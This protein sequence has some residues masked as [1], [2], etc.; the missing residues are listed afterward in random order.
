MMGR[1]NR[2][3]IPSVGAARDAAGTPVPRPQLNPWYPYCISFVAAVG[4]FLFGYDLLIM[5][6]AQLFLKDY[7]HLD[8]GQLGF[9]VSSAMLGCIAGPILGS[10]VCD[11]LGRKRT[12]VV[13]SLLFGVSAIGTA[14]P[15]TIGQ[16]NGFRMICGLGIGLASVASPMY[17]AEI[18]PAGIRGRLVTMNQLAIVIGCIS[19]SMVSYFLAKCLPETSSWR[20]MFATSLLPA[21]ILLVAL[22]PLADTPR[23]LASKGRLSEA[24]AVLERIHGS[25]EGGRELRQIEESLGDES[26]SYA[27]LFQ[28]GLR[29]A[30]VAGVFVALMAQWTGWSV[31]SF[32]LPMIFQKANAGQAADALFQLILAN[33]PILLFTIVGLYLIDRVGRRTMWLGGSL[34]MVVGTALLGLAFFTNTSGWKVLGAVLLT[35]VP[36]AIVMGP[37]SWLIISEIFPTRIR[38]RA[39]GLCTLVNWCASWGA[40]YAAPSLFELFGRRYGSPAGLFWVFSAVSLLSFLVALVVLPE[41]KGRSLEDIAEFWLARHAKSR[42]VL[43]APGITGRQA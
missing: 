30:L 20:W 31:I 8:A 10:W 18:A 19:A 39:A 27:E 17:I 14:L 15:A 35:A 22:F 7:F 16:F 3:T 24:A 38:A 26:G 4:G 5:T 28:P 29:P 2:I 37:L 25:E 23:W 33:V 32:Y 34:A 11:S 9:A 6:G 36:H 43:P 21:V 40:N 42:A 1:T 13:A 12:L 41:T